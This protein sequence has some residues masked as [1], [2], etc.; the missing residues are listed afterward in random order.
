LLNLGKNAIKEGG[1]A[2]KKPE[3]KKNDGLINVI[4]LVGYIY[5]IREIE[6]IK[7]FICI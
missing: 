6:V 1:N 3:R 7:L 4:G 5:N 2:L